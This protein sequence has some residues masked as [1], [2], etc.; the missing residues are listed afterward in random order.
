MAKVERDSI[1]AAPLV[2]AVVG[3][4]TFFVLYSLAGLGDMAG[5]IAGMPLG[6]LISL[7]MGAIVAAAIFGEL[8]AQALEGK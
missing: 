8:L 1:I 6:L 3:V 5:D 4:L 2:G 7:L